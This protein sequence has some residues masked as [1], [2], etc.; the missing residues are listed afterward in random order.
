MTVAVGTRLGADEILT[1]LGEA[2]QDSE[3]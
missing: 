1:L 3:R 2:A